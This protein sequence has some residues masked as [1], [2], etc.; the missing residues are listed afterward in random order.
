MTAQKRYNAC[1]EVS[2]VRA[3][4]QS[5]GEEHA[6]RVRSKW[7]ARLVNK[8]AEVLTS[9]HAAGSWAFGHGEK[10]NSPDH[11]GW[12]GRP[13]AARSGES[14]G[15]TE[16]GV[17]SQQCSARAHVCVRVCVLSTTVHSRSFG[18]QRARARAA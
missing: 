1:R 8:V 13:G 11:R 3:P 18:E 9:S 12:D 7:R 16:D 6:R 2:R 15:A 5:W 14:P 17:C 4:R 10:D